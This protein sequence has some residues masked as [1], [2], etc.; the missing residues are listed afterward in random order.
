MSKVLDFLSFFYAADEVDE[1]IRFGRRKTSIGGAALSV[2]IV[3]LIF[4]FLFSGYNNF[5]LWFPESIFDI[6][7]HEEI[8]CM[9]FGS[10]S[11]SEIIW[12]F[13]VGILSAGIYILSRYIKKDSEISYV[14]LVFLF[15]FS[16]LFTF[17]IFYTIIFI[18]NRQEI[19]PKEVIQTTVV[20]KYRCN[21]TRNV[22]SSEIYRVSNDIIFYVDGFIA[23]AEIKDDFRKYNVG[24][25]IN[26]E[27][28]RGCWGYPISKKN[29]KVWK[30]GK[31]KPIMNY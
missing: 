22:R 12:A 11:T 10:S 27:I 24:D 19:M 6:L 18:Y 28:Q 16:T 14:D 8:L 17:R 25:T 3:T 31:E 15:V 13:A 5:A 7:T 21:H 29:Y 1:P 26:V 2:I 9:I 4:C 23:H 30:Y 20:Y